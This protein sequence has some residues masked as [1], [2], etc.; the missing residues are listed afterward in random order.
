M[1]QSHLI[2]IDECCAASPLSLSLSPGGGER[3]RSFKL[4]PLSPPGSGGGGEGDAAMKPTRSL[5]CAPPQGRTPGVS[6]RMPLARTMRNAS[7][8]VNSADP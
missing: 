5:K 1:E 3:E 6:I 7:S 4:T 8:A 2:Q